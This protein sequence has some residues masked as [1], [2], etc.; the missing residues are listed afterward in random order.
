[1]TD[2]RLS[3]Y[4]VPEGNPLILRV[5]N[6]PAL[7]SATALGIRLSGVEEAETALRLETTLPAE[8]VDGELVAAFDGNMVGTT[9]GKGRVYEVTV[10]EPVD[11]QGNVLSHLRGGSDYPRT[12]FR[13]KEE[14]AEPMLTRGEAAEAAG[15]VERRR[16][17][18]YSEYIGDSSAPDAKEFRLLMFVE[19]LRITQPL[20]VPGIQILVLTDTTKSAEPPFGFGA[21]DEAELI[22]TMLREQG[23]IGPTGRID[24]SWGE[25][26]AQQ[27]PVV[28]MYA[29]RVFAASL[30]KALWLAHGQ[31]DR[32]LELLAFH[33]E[34]LGVPFATAIQQLDH[35]SGNYTD[36][37]VYP[38]VETYK[39]NLAGGFLSGENQTVLLADYRAMQSEPFLRFV[40]YLHAEA[41]AERNLDFAYFRCWNL[42]ETIASER[43][44]L[45]DLV[46]DFNG[47]RILTK[48]GSPFKTEW[49]R[50]RVYELVKRSMKEEGHDEDFYQEARD[51]CLGL[52]DAVHV[53]YAFRNATA[54]YGGFNPNDPNQQKQPWYEAAVEAQRNGAQRTG[55][56]AD[57]YFGYLKQAAT[58][59]VGWELKAAKRNRQ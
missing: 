45:G 23:W 26:N 11:S 58:D 27:R 14:P 5:G 22:N 41:Q 42:L 12:F 16:A 44:A 15:A 13:V 25:S 7:A 50:G 3:S 53:W 20:Q 39:G 55:G 24:P 57:P 59:V 29:P 8:F 56:R 6:H 35:T 21:N 40:L 46:T 34:A 37:R 10:L 54:H 18:M 51:L 32:L 49:A 19:R 33:R 4:A 43:V 1:M 36:L 38:E 52:W 28:V 48:D 2:F 30:G 17:E 31:R 47:D 9:L